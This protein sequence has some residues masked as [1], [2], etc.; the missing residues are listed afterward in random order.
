MAADWLRIVALDYL[1]RGDAVPKLPFGNEPIRDG[2]IVNIAVEASL[3]DVPS[4]TATEAA[5]FLDVSTACVTQLSKA[6]ALDN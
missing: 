5:G 6:G 1:M 4:V 2:K 3:A